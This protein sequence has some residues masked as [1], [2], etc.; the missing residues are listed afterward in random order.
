MCGDSHHTTRESLQKERLRRK[1]ELASFCD[2]RGAP[3]PL[4]SASIYRG[5]GAGDDSRKFWPSARRRRLLVCGRYLGRERCWQNTGRLCSGYCS[6]IF[7][8]DGLSR[9]L[10]VGRGLLV[11]PFLSGRPQV[12]PRRALEE[13]VFSRNNPGQHT[14]IPI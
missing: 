9:C 1:P 6:M 7:W 3:S 11:F 10:T 5:T 14:Y 13:D 12:L 4:D 8:T 2:F